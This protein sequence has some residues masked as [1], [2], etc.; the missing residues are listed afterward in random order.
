MKAPKP[1]RRREV[2]A[3]LA[4]ALLCDVL[5]AFAEHTPDM[6]SFPGLPIVELK[7]KRFALERTLVDGALWTIDALGGIMAKFYQVEALT[8]F[9]TK[10]NP[11]RALYTSDDVE[12]TRVEQDGRRRAKGAA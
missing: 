9:P 3:S 7:G 11:D 8:L 1:V 2:S 12:W 5:A 4:N 6:R 10:A